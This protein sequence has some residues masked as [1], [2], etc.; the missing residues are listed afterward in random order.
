ML[1]NDWTEAWAADDTPDPLGMPLQNMVTMDA[2]VRTS[3]Y[4]SSPHAQE[5]GFN[6]VGQ[7]VGMMNEIQSVRDLVTDLVEGYVDAVGHLQSLQ[8][9]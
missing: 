5:V 6:P 2:V 4:A 7:T 1:R 8:P 3:R 9:E